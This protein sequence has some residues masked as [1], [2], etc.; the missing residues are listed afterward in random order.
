M[1]TAELPNPVVRVP[2][3]A[4]IDTEALAAALRERVEG[5]VRFDDGSR[6]A[7]STDA[8]NFRQVPLGVVVPRSPDDAVEALAVARQ[9]G[10]PVL[11]RG[12]GTSLA[13]QCTNTA[14]VLDWSKYCSELESVDTERGTC[15]VQPGIVLDD[16]NRQLADTGLRFGP[17]PATHMN[18]TLGG[19]IG[20]NSCGA[21][22]QRTGKVVDNIVRLE[23]LL[24]DGTRFWCGK[25]SDEEY[26]EIEHHGDRRAA[27]Y[28]QLRRLRDEYADE[29]RRRFPDIPRRVSGYNLDSLLPEPGFD[30]AGLLVG[31]ES[32]L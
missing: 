12:G 15:V 10:A 29:I 22:A 31:S 28:R 23:V 1:S 6:A 30:V 17:E 25:T 26:A 11:S 21:T 3:P 2:E 8:S 20:N 27:I 13:G 19:M 5:E 18:C 32:T 9:F 14:V 4:E 24:A 16:L 7:Y